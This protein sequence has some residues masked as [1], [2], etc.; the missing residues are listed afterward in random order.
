MNSEWEPTPKQIKDAFVFRDIV[1]YPDDPSC[2]AMDV[3]KFY[4]GTVICVKSEG[5]LVPCSVIDTHEFGNVLE[6]SLE[7]LVERKKQRLLFLDFRDPNKLPGKCG[8]CLNNINCFGCR[9][10]AYYYAGD[11]LAVDPKCNQYKKIVK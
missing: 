1:N 2:G 8:T 7:D 3:S 4:C 10:S 9:S 6:D 11:I 5:W